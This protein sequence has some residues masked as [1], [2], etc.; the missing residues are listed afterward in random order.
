MTLVVLL[1]VVA[2]THQSASYVF[3]DFQGAGITTS[4]IANNAY[5]FFVGMLMAQFT[6]ALFPWH[7]AFA[8]VCAPSGCALQLSPPPLACCLCR[9]M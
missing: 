3:V 8:V 7:A 9:G 4:G 1:P 5:I 6:C 2:P